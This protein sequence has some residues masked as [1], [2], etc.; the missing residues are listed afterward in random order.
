MR[1][2]LLLLARLLPA[3]ALRFHVAPMQCYTNR[4]LRYLL[5]RLNEDV[6]LWTEMEK[7]ADLLSSDDVRPAV[8]S[9]PSSTAD[10][11]VSLVRRRWTGDYG[12]KTSSTRS[13]SSS[14]A[15]MP[16]SLRVPRNSP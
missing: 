7:A 8:H 16:R 12:T 15:A 9:I 5:R 2:A 13:C 11:L 10:F 6:I 14:A 3:I 1:G 4:H